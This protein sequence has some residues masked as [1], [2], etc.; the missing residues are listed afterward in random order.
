MVKIKLTRMGKRG[1]PF[2]RIIVVESSKTRDGAYIESLGYYNPMKS[3][4]EIKIDDERALYWLQCGAQPT[5]TVK[6]LLSKNG[7]MKTYHE[8]RFAKVKE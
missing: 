5:E 7:I 2:Y 6:S 3:P 8:K 1:Q 4:F